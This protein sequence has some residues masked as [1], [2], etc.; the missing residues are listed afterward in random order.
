MKYEPLEFISNQRALEIMKNGTIDELRVL[1]FSMGEYCDDWKFA[2][3]LCVK[4]LNHSDEQV[5]ANAVCGLSYIARNHRMLDKKQIE[6]LVFRI[7][8]ASAD[9]HCEEK[10]REAIHDIYIF[11]KWRPSLRI[12]PHWIEFKL[13]SLPDW[14]EYIK[15]SI[16]SLIR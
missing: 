1:P 16:K 15:L 3:N 9:K 5:R 14:I 12:L 8:K 11:M 6:N 10:I 7:F 4:L 13:H 2:Q